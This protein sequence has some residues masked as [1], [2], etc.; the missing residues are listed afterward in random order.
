MLYRFHVNLFAMPDD[1][2]AGDSIK[3]R[4][5]SIARQSDARGRPPKFD[6]YFDVTFE[7]AAD[8]L[9][10]LPRLDAEADG[11]FL[12]SGD[13][14][15][16][17]WQVDGHLFDFAGR[18]HRVE[19]HGACPTETFDALLGCVGWPQTALAFELVREGVA[20]DEA[21]FRRWADAST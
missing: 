19:L 1:L 11:F 13:H 6:S 5:L 21:A 8:A 10:S 2:I 3:L 14:D 12:I 15:G 9:R 7:Q 20:L 16:R 17:R 18:L 4:E